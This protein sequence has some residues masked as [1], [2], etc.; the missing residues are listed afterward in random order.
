MSTTRSRLQSLLSSPD[1]TTHAPDRLSRLT[2]AATSTEAAS[3]APSSTPPTRA[4]P[5]SATAI[6]RTTRRNRTHFERR[7]RRTAA[8]SESNVQFSA[9]GGSGPTSNG[10]HG[11][12]N[13]TRPR[14][15]GTRYSSTD[16]PEARRIAKLAAAKTNHTVPVTPTSHRTRT[17][18]SLSGA[19][20]SRSRTSSTRPR[21]ALPRRQSE[22]P[23]R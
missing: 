21:A 22:L 8:P 12:E 10:G 9:P 17:A 16:C 23:R 18:R 7:A 5:G 1:R 20:C 15:A 6:T 3:A 14:Q 19:F 4:T 11:R 2:T 13:A